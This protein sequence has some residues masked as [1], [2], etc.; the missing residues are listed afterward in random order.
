[1]QAKPNRTNTNNTTTTASLPI[2]IPEIPPFRKR[3]N[4]HSNYP[5]L[6]GSSPQA[7]TVTASVSPP[8][9]ITEI[10]PYKPRKSKDL[11]PTSESHHQAAASSSHRESQDSTIGGHHE[12]QITIGPTGGAEWMRRLKVAESSP[13]HRSTDCIVSS[14]ELGTSSDSELLKPAPSWSNVALKTE[15]A[16]STSELT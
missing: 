12:H 16:A 11:T 5:P 3:D 10:P 7:F 1:M 13:I 4:Q 15:Q 14:K 2:A 6:P 9:I 8:K